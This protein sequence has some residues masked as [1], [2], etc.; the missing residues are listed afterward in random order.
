MTKWSHPKEMVKITKPLPV[1]NRSVRKPV[2]TLI[3][4]KTSF[5]SQVKPKRLHWRSYSVAFKRGAALSPARK[6]RHV[7]SINTAYNWPKWLGVSTVTSNRLESDVYLSLRTERKQ[8][9]NV[10]TEKGAKSDRRLSPFPLR[11][12]SPAGRL[13]KKQ[14]AQ[15]RGRFVLIG[16]C[17]L[18]FGENSPANLGDFVNALVPTA[19]RGPLVIFNLTTSCL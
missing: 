14:I 10:P 12:I 5:T 17:L 15:L 6:I 11:D 9:T 8:L 7:A 2:S 16:N 19:A 3:P 18:S 1:K 13:T 4:E